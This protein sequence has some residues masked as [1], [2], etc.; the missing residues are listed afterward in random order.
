MCVFREGGR[1]V[2]I[3]LCVC[4]RACVR[5]SLSFMM[6]AIHAVSLKFHVHIKNFDHY[7]IVFTQTVS[8]ICFL[9]VVSCKIR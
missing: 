2:D 6:E 3:V 8:P 5:V 4:A 1:R 7:S 9:R